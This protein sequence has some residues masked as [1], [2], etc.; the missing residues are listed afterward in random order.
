[1][2]PIIQCDWVSRRYGDVLAVDGVSFTVDAGEI[3]GLVGPNGAG[4]TILIEMIESLRTPDSGS[5]RVLGLNPVAQQE[6]LQE[7]IGVQLQTTSIQPNIKVG[8]RSSSSPL[9]TGSRSRT[10]G[11]SS[12]S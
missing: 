4:K 9:S 5:I 1:M 3:F 2:N 10:P 6:E 7:R 12:S 11:I 8:R